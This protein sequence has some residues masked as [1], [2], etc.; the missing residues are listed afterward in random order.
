MCS[1]V[2][3]ELAT[4]QTVAFAETALIDCLPDTAFQIEE[5]C[6]LLLE[7]CPRDCGCFG[8]SLTSCFAASLCCCSQTGQTGLASIERLISGCCSH[9]GRRVFCDRVISV[10]LFTNRASFCTQTYLCLLIGRTSG[11]ASVKGSSLLGAHKKEL[12]SV[13][14]APSTVCPAYCQLWDICLLKRQE[15][16]L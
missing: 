7:C 6:R 16:L 2:Y 14:C 12:A 5:L 11:E 1:Y 13:K 15:K 10:L 8:Q 4:R 3:W 9:N